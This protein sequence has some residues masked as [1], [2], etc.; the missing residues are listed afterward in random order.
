MVA[1]LDA[2][3]SISWW[4]EGQG[5]FLKSG[6]SLCSIFKRGGGGGKRKED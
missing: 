6:D 2:L 3:V 1:M 5:R 4:G